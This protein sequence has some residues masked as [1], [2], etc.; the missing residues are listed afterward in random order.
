L[1]QAR[2]L[3]S[4][5]VVGLLLFWVYPSGMRILGRRIHDKPVA[6]LGWGVVAFFGFIALLLVI[7][8]ATLIVGV[9]LSV[10]TLGM[11]ARWVF[12]LGILGDVFLVAAYFFYVTFVVPVVVPYASMARLDRGRFW[13]LLPVVIGIPLY[14]VLTALPYVGG[15]LNILFILLGLG[16][17]ML[18]WRLNGSGA[19]GT[20]EESPQETPP[21]ET[22]VMTEPSE[23]L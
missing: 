2:R 6:S 13:W 4:L 18:H 5:L 19:G 23:T 14:V 22:P 3:I 12:L 21:E 17:L 7:L 20:G 1:D 11:L 15:I 8:F 16:A 9:L 10:V